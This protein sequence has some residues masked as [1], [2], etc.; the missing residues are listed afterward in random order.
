MLSK[1]IQLQPYTVIPTL[2]GSD[3][4]GLVYNRNDAITSWLRLTATSNRVPRLYW[5][6]KQIVEHN[7]MLS[8]GKQ[9]QPYTVIPTLLGSFGV[10]VYSRNDAIMSWLMADTHFKPLLP[11][12]LDIKTISWAQW[13]AVQRHT[14]AAL[15]SYT[16]LTWLWFR[17]S[18]VQ[19]KWCHYV[20]VEA[21]SHLKP[22]PPSILDI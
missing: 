21:D 8:K 5:T 3:F 22:R 16:H 6:Y 4:G 7:E 15:Y 12:I 13:D 14:V 1:G 17:G 9:L 10:L 20:M 18:G 2:L 11:S 19:P